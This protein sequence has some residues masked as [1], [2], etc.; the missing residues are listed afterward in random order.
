M[1]NLENNDLL[2]NEID[3]SR[4]I[5]GPIFIPKPRRPPTIRYHGRRISYYHYKFRDYN[6]LEKLYEQSQTNLKLWFRRAHYIQG[7]LIEFE[8]K[9]K[10]ISE[11]YQEM[12]NENNFLARQNEKLNSIIANLSESKEKLEDDIFISSNMEVYLCKKISKLTEENENL[13]RQV[14]ICTTAL[15]NN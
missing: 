5:G 11:E 3:Q 4:I 9:A 15:T 2:L 6:R 8:E 10:K 14:E 1:Q 13:K 7:E 12:R